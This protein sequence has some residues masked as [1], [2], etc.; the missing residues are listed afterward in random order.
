MSNSCLFDNCYYQGEK[1]QPYDEDIRVPLIV[2]GPG[3]NSGTKTDHIA[4]NIDIVRYQLYGSTVLYLLI[5][6]TPTF[7]DLAGFKVPEDID[8]ISL[9]PVLFNATS[10]VVYLFYY[11][12]VTCIM[13]W[14][15]DF[16]VEYY[17]EGSSPSGCM[18]E[19]HPPHGQQVFLHGKLLIAVQF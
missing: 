18:G 4:L 19:I 10:M 14:R 5:T 16:M 1:R 6:Q 8:G 9:K 3:I 17:G 2:R 11:C 13:Q 12:V 15:D 7:L